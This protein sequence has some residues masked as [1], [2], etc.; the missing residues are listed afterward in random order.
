M[1]DWPPSPCRLR[2]GLTNARTG[3]ASYAGGFAAV[4]ANV[5]LIAYIIVAMREDE[6]ERHAKMQPESKKDR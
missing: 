2:V 6:S 5:V 3:N 4:V 1:T